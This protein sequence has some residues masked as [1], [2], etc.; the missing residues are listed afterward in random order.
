MEGVARWLARVDSIELDNPHRRVV[1]VSIPGGLPELAW[2][3]EGNRTRSGNYIDGPKI[4]HLRAGIFGTYLVTD[5][6]FSVRFNDGEIV[7]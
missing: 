7:Q 1:Q 5:G 4:P 2:N 6:A 3:V